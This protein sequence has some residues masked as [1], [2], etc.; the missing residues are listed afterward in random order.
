MKQ[1]ELENCGHIRTTRKNSNR[2]VRRKK[3]CNWAFEKQCLNNQ[4]EELAD[5]QKKWWTDRMA[6]NLVSLLEIR[7]DGWLEKG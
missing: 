5:R 7:L 6:E 4:K 2:E 1:N 3:R